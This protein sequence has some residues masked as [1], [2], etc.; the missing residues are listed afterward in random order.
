MRAVSPGGI[1]SSPSSP[2][3]CKR[4]VVTLFE[5]ALVEQAPHRLDGIQRDPL[6]PL[7][8]ACPGG[9]GKAADKAVQELAHDLV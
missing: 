8:D 6:G 5:D 4:A 9:R 1:S 3:R 2:T 7:D